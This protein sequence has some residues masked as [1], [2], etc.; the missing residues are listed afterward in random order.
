MKTSLA[1]LLICYSFMFSRL[2]SAAP[3][4]HALHEEISEIA[5]QLSERPSLFIQCQLRFA[6]DCEELRRIFFE[7]LTVI[8]RVDN[9]TAMIK[10][11][12]TD[13]TNP[14][15]ILVHSKWSSRDDV[16]MVDFS[17]P[18][19]LLPVEFDSMKIQSELITLLSQGIVPHIRVKSGIG[20]EEII[21]KSQENPTAPRPQNANGPFYMDISVSGSSFRSGIGAVNPDG[22]SAP[23]SSS[24]FGNGSLLLNH[25]TD[26]TRVFVSGNASYSRNSQPGPDNTTISA[27]NFAPSLVVV[28]VYSLTKNKRWNVAIM[29]I[30]SANRGANL[31]RGSRSEVGIEYNLVPF[32]VT[33]S[34]EFRVRASGSRTI[35]RL[36]VAND[37]GNTHENYYQAAFQLYGY[38]LLLQDKASL[39]GSISANKN[40]SH[41]GY[42]SASSQLSFSF[43]ISRGVRLSASGSYAYQA[44]NMRFPGLPDF[45]NPL[46]TQF[47]SGFSGG[48]YSTSLGVS[49]TLG[50]GSSIY[51]RDRR[52]Q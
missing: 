5:N 45:S 28:G 50:K 13:E 51:A 27:E 35:D 34:Y 7:K 40:L 18:D 32:R 3:T 42:Y 52:F 29:G 31:I 14:Q 1:K 8:D 16:S 41:A 37:R 26:R 33:Q 23:S 19:L 2:A 38:W 39:T 49:F 24:L 4:L 9:D 21:I 10:V 43:Q 22:T 11:L 25:S 20:I 44:R 12:L 47:L 48:S 36:V 46:Q 17:L 6:M 30:E 15:G